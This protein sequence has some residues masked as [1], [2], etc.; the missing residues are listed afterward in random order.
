MTTTTA[1]TTRQPALQPQLSAIARFGTAVTVA[2]LL[3][4]AWVLAES[5]SH[6][7]V[8]SAAAAFS[9]ESQ[10]AGAAPVLRAAAAQAH[11]Q[12]GRTGA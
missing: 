7:A 10:Q 6:Q 3:A 12:R 4:S 1:A 11:I 5:A 2:A 8:R 9:G